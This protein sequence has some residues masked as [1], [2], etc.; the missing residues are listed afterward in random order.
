MRRILILFLLTILVV[1]CSGETEDTNTINAALS[2][3]PVTLDVMTNPTLTGRI[4]ASGNIYE[5]LLVLDGE[6]NIKEELASSYSLSEDMK[7]LVFTLREGVLFHDGKE[8]KA[9]DVCASMNRYLLLYS[10]A[11]EMTGGA[12]FTVT[13]EYEISIT[14]EKSLLFLPYLIASSPQEAIVM[15]HYLID[16]T[17][18]VT[19]VTGTGPYRLASWTSGEK[20]VLERFDSY[21]SYG[22]GSNG[23][24]GEKRALSERIVYWFV[25]DSVTRLLGLESGQYD[26]INDVMSTDESRIEKNGSLSLIRADESGSIALV[27]NKKEGPLQD[28]DVRRAVSY[29]VSSERLMAALYG[30]G[31]YTTSS[32]YMEAWQK[33]WNTSSLNPYEEENREKALELL[34]G[35][36]KIKLRI[37]S[38]SLSNLD[39][40]ASSLRDEL[41]SIG[42]ECT[43]TILDWASFIEERQSSDWDIYIS[44]FT[45]V[46]LPQMKSYLLPSFPGG[47]EETSEAYSVIKELNEA[48]SFEEAEALWKKGQ[49]ILWSYC[50]VYIAGHYT[51]SYASSSRLSNIIV[52][53]GFFFWNSVKEEKN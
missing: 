17:N 40:L 15:P 36:G 33:E 47:I 28:E 53:N 11:G 18:L 13:G 27:F 30:D 19:S 29:A 34:E 22:G 4:I 38:S 44:A 42:I 25:P 2:Q 49:E 8:M 6:G 14:S 48:H 43:L 39:R 31:I 46:P 51:T 7:T 37:L 26:F 10:R 9:E 35:K 50:P 32:L 52:Q 16:G 20:I 3:E 1:S 24:W 41:E 21:S 45:S 5:K 23:R 12:L